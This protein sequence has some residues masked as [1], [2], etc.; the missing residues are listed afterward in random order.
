[1]EVYEMDD[2]VHG[3]ERKRRVIIKFILNYFHQ[4][5]TSKLKERKGC[6]I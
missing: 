3:Q 1:M 4:H 5:N 2:T 6:K